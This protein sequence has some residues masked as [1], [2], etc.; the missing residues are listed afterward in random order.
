VITIHDRL[1][2]T[3]PGSLL[4]VGLDPDPASYPD[5]MRGRA[6]LTFEFCR[7]I[8]DATH[9][10]VCAFKPQI[11][12]FSAIGAERALEQTIAHIRAVA[13]HV[14]VILDAKRG[15]IGS[16]AER[17][18]AEAFDRYGADAVTVSPYL[19]FDTIEPFL[20]R[21]SVFALCKTSNPGSGDVQGLC[22][23]GEPLYRRLARDL[24]ARW[25]SSGQLGLVVGATYPAELA[26]V[27]S[28]VGDMPVL[29]PG[30]GVQ[31]ATARDVTGGLTAE[32]GVV[33]NASRAVIYAGSSAAY[34]TAARGVAMTLRAEL[35]A[36]RG[37]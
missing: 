28:V 33:C 16:T 1:R 4:C 13:P 18:A 36:V 8:V 27:R 24:A 11:A 10:L 31:G 22:I 15:D 30:L 17:Y 34:A 14:P 19:G 21:G 37:A 5:P 20:A 3:W 25:G 29:V 12:F 23:D 35:T 32:G 9:D 6:D 26:D 7:D 2:V